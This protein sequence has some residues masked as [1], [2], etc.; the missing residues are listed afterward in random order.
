[1]VFDKFEISEGD[2]VQDGLWLGSVV[3][4]SWLAA[5]GLKIIFQNGT[6]GEPWWW[7]TGGFPSSHT[8]PA[9][10]LALGIFLLQGITVTFI[11]SVVFLVAIIRDAVGV[12]Y[13]TGINAAVLK[14][15]LAKNIL[16][17][18]VIIEKGHTLIQTIAGLLVGASA[19]LIGYWVL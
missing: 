13:A 15:F 11:F 17:K 8:A 1:M 3:V 2:V 14:E 4:A 12:R 7:R 19:A 5:Q 9:S 16:G 18:K 10:A 6:P